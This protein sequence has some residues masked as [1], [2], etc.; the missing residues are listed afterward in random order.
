[1]KIVATAKTGGTLTV[2]SSRFSFTGMTGTFPDAVIT[3]MKSVTG[4][5]GPDSVDATTGKATNTAGGDF[6]VA[7]T[8]QTGLTRYAPMQPVPPTKITKKKATP[9]YPTS[10]VSIATTMLPI[11][12]VQTTITQS[13]THSVSSMENT[14]RHRVRLQGDY[15]RSL[16]SQSSFTYMTLRVQA[17]PHY[18]LLPLQCLQ[19]LWPSSSTDGKTR[20]LCCDILVLVLGWRSGERRCWP[21]K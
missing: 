17:N 7:Y 1:M 18:R 20:F 13:Q 12:K 6:G 21:T 2:Y 16:P 5:D 8:M 19:I 14:V 4:T 3:G 10:S 11:P 9:Q 15:V